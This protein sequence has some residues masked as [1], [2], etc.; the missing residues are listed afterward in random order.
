MSNNM[1]DN[2]PTDEPAKKKKSR[3]A[4]LKQFLISNK[5]FF[6]TIM[7][8]SLSIAG[9]VLAYSS[10]RIARIQN[11]ISAAQRDI[12][13]EASSPII[14]LESE[15]DE[16]GNINK[17]NVINSGGH[18]DTVDVEIYPYVWYDM[19]LLRGRKDMVISNSFDNGSRIEYCRPVLFGGNGLNEE[20]YKTYTPHIKTG[21]LLSIQLSDLGK[22]IKEELSWGSLLEQVCLDSNGCVVES[23]SEYA[24]SVIVR[25]SFE[26]LIRVKY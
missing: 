20:I 2:T 26:Y 17:V 8:L 4:R 16:H 3:I 23:S 18:L 11:E 22:Y 15:Y 25:V 10:N 21:V 5:I 7:A 24:Y 1:S 19:I 12:E 14:D 6:E 13:L 9:V